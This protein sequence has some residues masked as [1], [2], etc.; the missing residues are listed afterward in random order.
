MNGSENNRKKVAVIITEY[1]HNSHAEVIVGRLLGRLGYSPRVDV[2]SMY[3]D[4]VPDND[5]SRMEAAAYGIPISPTI[6][7][8][9]AAGGRGPIDGVV[10][11]GE[12]GNYPINDKKQKMYPRR[13]LIEQVLQA[14]D[15]QGLRV[16]IFSDKHLAY[17]FKDALWIY[18]EIKKRNIP[19]MGGS[20][21]PFTDFVPSFNTSALNDVRELMVVSFGDTEAYGFHGM[22][23]MQCL[24]EK[25]LGGETGIRSIHTLTGSEVWTAM[26]QKEW[27]EDLLLEALGTYRKPYAGHPR[28]KVNNPDLFVIEYNDGVKGYVIQLQDEVEQWSFAFRNAIGNS[29]AAWCDSELERPF[30]HFGVLTH[31]I[32]DLIET[33][34]S[35]FPIER[36]LITTGMID[37]GMDSLYLRRKLVTPELNIHYKSDK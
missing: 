14:M 11:I 19:F 12:H 6:A 9:I 4:Q 25:R 31:Y 16:P 28:E 34:Q 13:R 21:I 1:R 36:T 2:V 10:V 18:A 29:I 30:S 27:P 20:S 7:E 17:D 22:E 24:A 33:R 8:A 26:D 15:G 32:E 37:Y 5:M 35:P 3:T 23:V